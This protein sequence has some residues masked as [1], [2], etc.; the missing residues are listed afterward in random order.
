MAELSAL[1]PTT[2]MQQ[3]LTYA[4]QRRINLIWEIT[5][6]SVAMIIT[7]SLVYCEINNV[8]SAT[9]RNGFFLIVGFYFSRTNHA[10][11]GGIGDKPSQEY[12]GR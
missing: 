10:Q 7:A 4:G 6:A 8:D 9:I 2:T 12:K 11:I 3:D 5:Q 1:A